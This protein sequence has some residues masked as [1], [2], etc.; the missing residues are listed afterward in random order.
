[1]LRTIRAKK[2]RREQT[3][4]PKMVSFSDEANVVAARRMPESV[5]VKS[6]PE[7][8]AVEVALG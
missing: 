7:T 6:R 2:K 8:T 5:S 4:P 1:M 3:K